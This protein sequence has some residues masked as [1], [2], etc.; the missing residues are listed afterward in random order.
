MPP[1]LTIFNS[2]LPPLSKALRLS[3]SREKRDRRR[4]VGNL[5]EAVERK[6]RGAPKERIWW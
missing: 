4:K 2:F 3:L 1:I 6:M 5:F